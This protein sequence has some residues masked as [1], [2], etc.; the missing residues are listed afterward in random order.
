VIH[1]MT[2]TRFRGFLAALLA[3]IVGGLFTHGALTAR[4]AHD[5]TAPT[6]P[7]APADDTAA[8]D[9]DRLQ[10]AWR[11]VR[12][13]ADGDAELLT[14][15]L[16]P[17]GGGLQ[18]LFAG[19]HW[20]FR[21][22][23]A[24]LSALLRKPA[25]VGGLNVRVQEAKAGSFLFGIGVNTDAG[26]TGSIV[27]NE[28][29]FDVFPQPVAVR[30][31]GQEFRVEPTPGAEFSVP[32]LSNRGAGQ[33]FRVPILSNREAGQEFR[34]EPI[35]GTP[36][37]RYS[38]GF[39]DAA[40]QPH[41]IDFHPAGGGPACKGIFRVGGNEL[42]LCLNAAAGGERPAR[43]A[44][45]KGSSAVLLVLKRVVPDA[46]KPS[47]DRAKLQGVWGPVRV[48]EAGDP[49]ALEKL[50]PPAQ[51]FRVIFSGDTCTFHD[52]LTDDWVQT[53][54]LDESASPRRIDLHHEKGVHRG[55]Y[56]FDGEE[57][58]LCLSME[59]DGERPKD[60]TTRP[61]TKLI[62]VRLR[63]LNE[64]APR[65]SAGTAEGLSP[66]RVD[67]LVRQVQAEREKLAG[68]WKR[69]PA[70]VRVVR[71]AGPPGEPAPPPARSFESARITPERMAF[72]FD[73]QEGG[74]RYTYRL[75]PTA[76][77]RAI[78]LIYE[79][80]PG[81]RGTYKLDGEPL[82]SRGIY[83]V[84]GDTLTISFAPP[85]FKRPRDFQSD[86]GG[87]YQIVTLKRPAAPKK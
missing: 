8:Q 39:R 10:G 23:T 28:R 9:R 50:T 36:S 24:R 44:A 62:F 78:D 79:E 22:D 20:A 18:L 14:T 37:A 73:G 72:L 57:L 2:V 42:T 45:R 81:G 4:P 60:F 53:Y 38:L 3:L 70:E 80:P 40:R 51:R 87:A 1:D 27:L 21:A 83:K 64:P 61:G 35:P 54:T 63:K 84:D 29:N 77:P 43:F 15:L 48:E 31:A 86:A 26:L 85:S 33:E 46:P 82:V 52:D 30:G 41:A 7:A 75:D 19:D 34:V 55:V 66:E 74:M 68:E 56:R 59:A 32:I 65:P 13:E 76:S 17:Q 6:A 49:D 11:V 67:A 58:S 12:A 16:G 47:G 69:V 71:P 25:A 5:P